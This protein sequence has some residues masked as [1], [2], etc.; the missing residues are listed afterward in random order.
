M[1]QD[2]ARYLSEFRQAFE[3]SLLS[4]CALEQLRVEEGIPL[5]QRGGVLSAAYV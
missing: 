4:L 1:C 3:N 2:V 5:H